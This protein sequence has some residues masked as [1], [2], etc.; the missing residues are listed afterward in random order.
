MIRDFK[1][2]EEKIIEIGLDNYA[3]ENKTKKYY[4]VCTYSNYDTQHLLNKDYS[5]S[6]LSEAVDIFLKNKEE[7]VNKGK[8]HTIKIELIT[9]FPHMKNPKELGYKEKTREV[10]MYCKT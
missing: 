9:M 7:F 10:V 5:G 1:E 2:L 4:T 8:K 6:E 3:K